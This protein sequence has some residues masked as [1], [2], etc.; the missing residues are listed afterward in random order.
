M[1]R[2]SRETASRKG[3]TDGRVWMAA[4][5]ALFLL[6]GCGRGTPKS[7]SGATGGL[8]PDTTTATVPSPAPTPAPAD[9]GKKAE[10]TKPVGGEERF[11][12]QTDRVEDRYQ[13][14]GRSEAGSGRAET[15]G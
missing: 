11:G 5:A 9:T 1:I 2:S 6:A 15:V 13:E 8:T 3:L 4:A 14:A 12:R 7:D 10:T